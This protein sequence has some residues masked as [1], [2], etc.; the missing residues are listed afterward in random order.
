MIMNLIRALLIVLNPFSSVVQRL[1]TVVN[2]FKRSE[3]ASDLR[4]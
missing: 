4:H 2:I 3:T 1:L